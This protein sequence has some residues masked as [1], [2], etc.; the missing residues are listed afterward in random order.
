MNIGIVGATGAVGQELIKIFLSNMKINKLNNIN[1]FY[2][3][4]KRSKGTKIKLDSFEITIEEFSIKNTLHC[5][6]L[7]L[8]VSGEFSLKY[9]KKLA[10][11]SYVIDNSSAF[12]YDKDVPLIVPPVNAQDYKGE[13]LIANPNCSS[14]IALVGLKP[15]HDNYHIEHMIVSTYQAA[16]GAGINGL[17]ELKDNTNSF[18]DYKLKNDKNKYFQYDLAYNVIPQVDKFLENSYTKEEMKVVWEVK[19]VL[20]APDMKISV[21]AVRVPILRSH[22]E[23]ITL[24]LKYKIDDISEV[25]KLLNDTDGVLLK[26]DILNNIYPMPLTSTYNYDVEIGR[27]RKNLIYGNT[28]LDMF[29]SGDQLLRGAAYNAYEIF[30]KLLY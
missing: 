12:R 26:D 1:L 28:G 4:S 30:F 27:L 9:A 3:A 8:C 15:I 10:K 20:N 18:E 29:I 2:Y 6:V 16:S 22:A 25:K 11:N 7:F 23:S 21:T 5:D 24:K 19:K 14:A 13:K 17:K